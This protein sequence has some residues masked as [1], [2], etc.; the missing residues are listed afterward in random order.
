MQAAVPLDASP[1]RAPATLTCMCF[2]YSHCGA[3]TGGMF[4][5]M[6]RRSFLSSSAALV[7]TGIISS[8]LSHADQTHAHDI[9]AASLMT[10][11]ANRFLAALDANQR[12]KASILFD[13]DE[14][15]NWHFIPNNIR[16][17][18]DSLGV[19]KGLPLREM[20]PDQ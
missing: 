14:R 16:V 4:M 6:K 12:G 5:C 20:S 7:G 13:S 3:H 2:L 9:H 18:F 15:I 19:R 1:Q 10:E 8:N 11:C 17:S